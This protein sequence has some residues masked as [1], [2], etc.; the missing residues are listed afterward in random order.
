MVP[1]QLKESH[2]GWKDLTTTG[3]V[4]PRLEGSHPDWYDLTSAGRVSLLLEG[5][6]CEWKG[7]NA[8]GRALLQLEGS[9]RLG[10]IKGSN[11]L[12]L[13]GLRRK[14]KEFAESEIV[15]R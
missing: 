4:P 10:C 9:R 12:W 13:E 2:P 15:E 1:P 14:A 7:F 5:S 8:A 6:H 11:V 3:R